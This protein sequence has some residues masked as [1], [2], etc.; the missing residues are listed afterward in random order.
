M[1]VERGERAKGVW[2][3]CLEPLPPILA[4]MLSTPTA[5]VPDTFEA[6]SHLQSSTANPRSADSDKLVPGTNL[7]S[8]LDHSVWRSK[9]R[10][11]DVIAAAD[12][13]PS[14]RYNS[15]SFRDAFAPSRISKRQATL[16]RRP[17]GGK[18]VSGLGG[19][20]T[21][22]PILGPAN[23]PITQ[24]LLLVGDAEFAPP[25]T[26][27]SPLFGTSDQPGAQWVPFHIPTYGQQVLVR[28]DDKGL[29]STLIQMP[30]PDVPR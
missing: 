4:A 19:V 25:E 23:W 30:D 20:H 18:L 2:G 27:P 24:Y 11:G 7:D 8:T 3:R 15:Q 17:D 29:E 1:I 12:L 10:L 6:Q 14:C 16:Q 28:L 9:R 21:S 22:Q 26:C 13:C 5:T